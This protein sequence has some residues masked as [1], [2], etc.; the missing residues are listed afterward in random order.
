MERAE[1]KLVLSV[2]GSPEVVSKL[3]QASSAMRNFKETP[4]T[5]TYELSKAFKHLGG[6]LSGLGSVPIIEI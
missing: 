2:D 6:S 5:E 4:I 3:Q 1:V